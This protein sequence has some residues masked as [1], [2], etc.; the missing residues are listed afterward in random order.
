MLKGDSKQV[1]P[2]EL[3]I[4]TTFPLTETQSF[5]V[6]IKKVAHRMNGLD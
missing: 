6:P 5:N 1:G 4:P 3:Q 2:W